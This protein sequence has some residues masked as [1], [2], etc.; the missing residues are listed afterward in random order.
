MPVVYLIDER[1][2]NP[3]LIL[4]SVPEA[5]LGFLVNPYF[6]VGQIVSLVIKGL[7][8]RGEKMIRG[9]TE[10]P[11]IS[12]LRIMA[13]GHDEELRLGWGIN[14]RNA[15]QLAPLSLYLASGASGR[16]SL[17]GYNAALNRPRREQFLGGSAIGERFG[18][19]G[20]GWGPEDLDIPDEPRFELLRVLARTLGV[21]V[22]AGLDTHTTPFD[23]RF[24]DATVTVDRFG[25]MTFTGMDIPGSFEVF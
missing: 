7:V 8:T 17:L 9:R 1:V 21:P 12:E 14:A 5:D 10:L 11:M 3:R 24:L 25:D 20:H 23:W 18:S 13:A 22:I 2:S 4:D 15:V 16:C 19:P 6:T